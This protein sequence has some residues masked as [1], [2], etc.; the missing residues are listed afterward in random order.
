MLGV[1]ILVAMLLPFQ[2][3]LYIILIM[4]MMCFALLASSFNLL[5][6][7]AGLLSL[8]HAAFFG[9]AAYM[10]IY[11]R[12]KWGIT[13]EIAVVL[14]TA[15]SS[16]L[17]YAIGSLAVRK[18]GIYFAMIT[19][20]FAQMIFFLAIKLPQTGGED[21]LRAQRGALGG[22]V[23]LS[24]DTAMYYF[25]LV[26]F[27]AGLALTHRIVNS[28]FGEVVRA[29]RE[30]EPR[31]I[32]LGHDV[33]AFKRTI[34]TISAGLAGL[35]GSLE[36]LVFQLASLS[37]LDWHTSGD[38]VVM[39][40]LGGVGTLSGPIV[41][42]ALVV[43]LQHSLATMGSWSAIAN[44]LIFMACVL[45]FKRGLVEAL[46]SAVTGLLHRGGLK[47]GRSL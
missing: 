40:F 46:R 14:G 47:E 26:C 2:P 37:G 31:A 28:P 41:G 18:K 8:G 33:A 30:H 12:A 27:V 3:Y 44:G 24:N 13:P 23:D 20:A 7:F 16:A 21:G 42:A 5:L 32:S 35:A 10:T 22:V 29:I 45:T 4:K 34:F 43:G 11:A 38:V 9:T 36:A 6:G 39:T 15:I 19:L 25:V 17:G 1:V